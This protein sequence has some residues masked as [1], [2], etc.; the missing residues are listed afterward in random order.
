MQELLGRLR[1]LDPDAS[2]GLRVI[3]CFD[4]LMAGGVA[5]HGLLAAAAALA[6]VPVGLER[7]TKLLRVDPRG[8][9]L[10]ADPNA[11]RLPVAVGE[12]ATAWIER[13]A[14]LANDAIILERLA[15]ALRL[16]L[17]P[18]VEATA[19]RRD[20]ATL[21]DAEASVPERRD[22]ATRLRLVSNQQYRVLAAPLFAT[23]TQHPVAPDDVIGT[24]FGP[25]HVM[26]VTADAPAAGSP[27][28]LGIATD[29]DD[30]PVSLRTALIA[31]RLHAAGSGTDPVRAD[32]FGGLAEILADLD[33]RGIP[34]RD[35]ALI[36]AV[37]TH[38]W[39]AETIDALVR[40]TSVREAARMAGVH[41][42]T[43]TT[44]VESIERA[45]GFDPLSGLGRT[46]LGVA[47]LRWRLRSSHVLELPTP[48]N[49]G[50]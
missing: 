25:V 32:D 4:E 42:S 33:E 22:A 3:A 43:M 23:W 14:T 1:A 39:G 38:P 41:H 47:F 10:A 11:P 48:T 28:G 27:L 21:L 24:T 30:L 12:M 7:G 40:S 19:M 6:G 26:I 2:A 44:R 45:L 9:A 36:E 29:V 35:A 31:L 17:D 15:L 13:E 18:T 50:S 8:E 37:V 34:D 20:A 49:G 16:R 46:R 5:A